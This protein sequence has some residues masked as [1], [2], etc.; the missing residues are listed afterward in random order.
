MPIDLKQ[1][2]RTFEAVICVNGQAGK[3]SLVY[4]IKDEHEFDQPRRLQIEF[5]KSIQGVTENTGTEINPGEMWAQFEGEYLG[6]GRYRLDSYEMRTTSDSAEITAQVIADGEHLTVVGHGIGP[7]SAFVNGLRE[8]LGV[9]VDVLDYSEHAIGA[10][11]DTQAVAYVETQTGD[12]T[13]RERTSTRLHSSLMR[14][15]SAASCLHLTHNNDK[16]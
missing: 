15:S 13:V 11:A 8:H 1:V 2:V 6:I 16:Y 12:G 14:T 5:S 9:D 10:G 3:C 7:V 4:V